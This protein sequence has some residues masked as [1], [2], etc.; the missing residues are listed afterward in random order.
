MEFQSPVI[1][2]YNYKGNNTFLNDG[3]KIASLSK[4]EYV[5]R[6]LKYS[7]NGELYGS[8]FVGMGA[9]VLLYDITSGTPTLIKE[10]TLNK[11]ERETTT[12]YYSAY[13]ATINSEFFEG[14]KYRLVLPAGV[15]TAGP[16]AIRNYVAN[17]ET[18]VEFEG[19]TPSSVD[20][21]SCSIQ[22]DAELSQLAGIVWTFKG[23]F[24]KDPSLSVRIATSAGGYEI[25]TFV[26]SSNGQTTVKAFDCAADGSPRTLRAGTIYTAIFPEGLLYYAGDEAIKNTEYRVSFTGVA[27]TPEVIEPEF[28]NVKITTNDFL[29]TDQQ[30]VKGKPF[31]YTMDFEDET[32]WAVESVNQ[33]G[34]SLSVVDGTFTTS[35]LTGNT[36][37]DIEIAYKGQWAVDEKGTGVYEIR[38]TDISIFKD[39][40]FIVVTGVTPENTINVY[41]L[42]GMLINTTHVNGDNDTVRITVAPGQ[43]YIVTVDGVAAKIRM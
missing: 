1:G 19:S 42:A 25:P 37:I 14:H 3:D 30:A 8:G 7:Y 11:S 21:I 34:K 4:I 18:V 35:A 39:V 6:D 38:G 27:K 15:I 43:Y 17:E 31:T 36:D 32:P 9:S 40:D 28:V 33:N 24:V 13:V 23:D 16:N 5:V 22:N 10:I 12:M 2:T 29:I 26:S 20:M 41:N